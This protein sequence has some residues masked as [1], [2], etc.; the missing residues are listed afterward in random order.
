MQAS[1]AWVIYRAIGVTIASEN[2]GSPWEPVPEVS[3]IHNQLRLD[4]KVQLRQGAKCQNRT[5]EGEGGKRRE[6][7]S[8]RDTGV[9]TRKTFIKL[10]LC[11]ARIIYLAR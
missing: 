4:P 7:H 10:L 9:E 11:R 1:E 3:I 5:R 2:H 8:L 6:V